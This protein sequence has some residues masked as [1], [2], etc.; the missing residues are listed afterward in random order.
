MEGLSEAQKRTEA[1]MESLS[2]SM[3]GLSEA[4]KRT[5]TRMEELAE[6][7]TQTELSVAAFRSTADNTN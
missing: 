4:Q 3:E 1:R 5:E 2:Q 7:Q 6:A